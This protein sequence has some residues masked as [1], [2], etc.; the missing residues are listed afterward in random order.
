MENLF[1]SLNHQDSVFF[2]LSMLVSFLIGF[3]AAWLMWR[4][5]AKRHQREAA[6]WKQKYDS[7][8]LEMT[9]LREKLDLSTADLAKSKREAE[10]ALDQA[11]TTQNE[12]L[13]WQKDLDQALEE[14]VRL[15]VAS[16]SYQSTIEELNSQIAHLKSNNEQLALSSSSDTKPSEKLLEIQNDYHVAQERL[17]LLETKIAQLT[18]ENETL[19]SG[20]K[21][22]DENLLNLLQSYNDST[23]RLGSLEEKIGNL[24]AENEAL[25][26][27]LANFNIISAEEVSTRFIEQP[28][29]AS[30]NPADKEAITGGAISPSDAKNEVLAAIGN[31]IPTATADEKDDLT[32]IKGIGSFLEKKLNAL[33]IYKFEQVSKLT[34]NLVEKLT[35]AIEFFPGRIERDD[36]VGQ[37]AILALPQKK[38]TTSKAKAVKAE[39]LKIIEGIGPKIESLLQGAGIHT[40][41]DL[42]NASVEHLKE[43]LL[44]AGERYRVHDPSTWPDQAQLAANGEMEKLKEYQDFLAGGRMPGK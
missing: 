1:E 24:I 18:T 44:N 13:K 19:R 15:Q 23:H 42:S 17:S 21:K 5:A 31:T 2:L 36:W 38:K 8:N 9:A 7:L 11:T 3:I 16:N 43:I 20:I 6:S 34:P 14:T 12:K 40:L 22:E 27:E 39:D 37:A 10:I 32:E 35:T 41:T 25:R 29:M 30:I 33:G 4:G 28:I 26:S